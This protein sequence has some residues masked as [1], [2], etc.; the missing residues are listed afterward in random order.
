M[1]YIVSGEE[2][3]RIDEYT[4]N[5]VGLP[6]MVLMER[7][8][9]E[10]YDFIKSKFPHN[11][12]ILVVVESGNNGGDGV[13]LARILKGAGYDVEVYWV[14]GLNKTSDAFEQQRRI[15]KKLGVKFLDEIVN[16]GYD[17]VVD[18]IFGVGL[19]RN[20]TGKQAEAINLINDMDAFTIAIDIPSG[21]DSLTGFVLGCAVRADA[22][23]TFEHIKLGMLRGIGYEYSGQVRIVDIGFPKQAVDFVEP[24]LYTYDEA[25][26]EKLLPYR[27]SDSHKGSY[28]KICVIGGC[29]NMAGAPMFAAEAAYRMGCGLVKICTVEENREIIQT[30]LP[31]AMLTTYSPEDKDSMREAIRQS[32]SWADVIVLG[33]GLGI[34]EASEYLVE[35]VLRKFEKTI[36]LDADGLNIVSKNLEWLEDTN[37]K[38]IITPHLMEMSRLIDMKI[39][40]LREHK[41]DESTAFANKYGVVVVLKDART[42]VSDGG[43]QAYIN[44]TGN[45]GMATGGSGDVL[46]GIIAGLCGQNMSPFDA[47]KLGVY[48]HGMAGQEAAISKGRYSMIASDIVRSITKVLEGDYYV[49]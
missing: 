13:A 26:V 39:P 46:S 1:K 4:V 2:M 10:M 48:M 29:K 14:N 5:V 9:L 19:N 7:A 36:I 32:I 43:N 23:I 11:S 35:R 12:R 40:E 21:I 20:V 30:K 45:N 33:P 27:K 8:A 28:G 49:G 15:A 22:T 44:M 37:A 17:I 24:K 25:D 6:Q 47:A 16:Y 3:A 34:S 41:Y 42:I 38:V 31:E 18:A